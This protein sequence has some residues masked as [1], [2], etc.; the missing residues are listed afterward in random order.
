MGF[1]YF[2]AVS[3]SSF[4]LQRQRMPARAYSPKNKLTELLTDKYLIKMVV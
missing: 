3:L 2:N 1:F 4:P